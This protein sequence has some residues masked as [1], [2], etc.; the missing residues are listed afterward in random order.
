MVIV[1]ATV[2][3]KLTKRVPAAYTRESNGS[4]WSVSATRETT[5]FR[6]IDSIS[7]RRETTFVIPAQC[8]KLAVARYRRK[9]SNFF[10]D[11]LHV[12]AGATRH[13]IHPVP[14]SAFQVAVS[15]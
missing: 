8:K 7:R 4:S 10:Q 1:Q 2:E 14:F 6:H 11:D 9:N 15:Q 13:R 3:T 5:S 12:V